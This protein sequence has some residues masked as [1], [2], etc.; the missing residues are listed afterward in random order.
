MWFPFNTSAEG[1]R[2]LGHPSLSS[3]QNHCPM[4][5][6]LGIKLPRYLL[7]SCAENS[8]G[9]WAALC[10]AEAMPWAPFASVLVIVVAGVVV[11]AGGGRQVGGGW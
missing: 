6:G 10:A 8:C 2:N 5:S 9:T 7:Q 1:A 4:A 3:R 11:V